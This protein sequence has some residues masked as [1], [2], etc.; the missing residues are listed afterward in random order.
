MG[1]VSEFANEL[2][3]YIYVKKGSDVD[4]LDELRDSEA[5]LGK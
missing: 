2:T 5:E 3:S 1:F 4:T